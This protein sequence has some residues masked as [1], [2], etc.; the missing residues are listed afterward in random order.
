[1]CIRDRGKASVVTD[2]IERFTEDGIELK[3]G[4]TL[5]A[6]VVVTATGFNMNTMGDIGFSK[7]G[8]PF[9]FNETVTFKGTMFTGI[10]NL[11]YVFGYFRGSWT[12]RSEIIADFVCRML[13]HMRVTGAASVRPQ[14][15][16]HEQD[17]ELHS[18]VDEEDFNPGYLLR[19]KDLLPKRGESRDWRHTQ[20]HWREKDE[21]PAI[22]LTDEV[23][24]Y[25]AKSQ[26]SV[27]A[28]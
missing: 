20:D 9:A 14:L 18:W 7:D 10:P 2:H 5:K 3:S 26:S 21:F 13:N 4:E 27:A 22:D 17:M 19:A 6:D 24:Q 1:M 23:F 8:Q 25:R 16:P 15:R 12:L 11:A 28:E